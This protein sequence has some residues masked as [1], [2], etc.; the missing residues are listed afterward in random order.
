MTESGTPHPVVRFEGAALGHGDR[1]VLNDLDLDIAAGELVGVVGRSGAGKSTLLAA[2]SGASVLI[3]G[4]VEVS[5]RDPRRGNHPVGLVPQLGDEVF[6]QL[7]ISEVVALGSPRRGL[8][9]SRSERRRAD[10]LLAR[11]GLDGRQRSRLAELSGGQRQRVAIARALTSSQSLLLCDEPTSGADPAL[12]ADIVSVLA[13]VAAG[14]ATVMVATHDL[15]VVLPR[16]GRVLG[17]GAGSLQFDGP[18]TAFGPLQQEK[19]YSTGA[20]VEVS[21]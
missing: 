18:P 17:V 16:L 2:L 1:P 10:D 3:A 8:F 11:L 9:T 15:A 21:G 14:G 12:A 19:V 20:P 7:C 6:T 13:E 5:G 4:R